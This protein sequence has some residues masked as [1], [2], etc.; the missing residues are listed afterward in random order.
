M[1]PEVASHSAIIMQ[2]HCIFMCDVT[3]DTTTSHSVVR[4]EFINMI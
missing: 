2:M 4:P 3:T 1:Y